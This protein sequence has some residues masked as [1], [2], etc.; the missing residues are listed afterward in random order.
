ML[1]KVLDCM[2]KQLSKAF[3]K[4]Y[5]Y[6]VEDIPQNVKTPCFFIQPISYN[7]RSCGINRYKVNIPLVVEYY[8][9]NKLN[10][11]K[12]MHDTANK[13]FDA[14]EYLNVGGILVRSETSNHEI[15]NDVLQMFF[16][17][18]F[19]TISTKPYE[20]MNSIGITINTNLK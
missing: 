11:N 15:N 8:P 13:T 6:Y 4:D 10:D 2:T 14:L 12:K 9:E 7:I 17:Y 1:N 18:N 16:T 5:R 20:N 3:G 19:W